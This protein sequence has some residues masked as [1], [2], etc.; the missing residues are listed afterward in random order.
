VFWADVAFACSAV[1]FA[2]H[3]AKHIAEHKDVA[4]LRSALV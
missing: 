4:I 2:L 1:L 3:E